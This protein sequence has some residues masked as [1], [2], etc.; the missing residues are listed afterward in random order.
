ME[1]TTADEEAGPPR[2][3]LQSCASARWGRAGTRVSWNT[4]GV[5]DGTARQSAPTL[6]V[7]G[8]TRCGRRG[9]HPAREA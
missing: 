1:S 7:G 4:G 6:K 3:R 9:R 5:K 8:S 2:A